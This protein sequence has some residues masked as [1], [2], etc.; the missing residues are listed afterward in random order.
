[1][2]GHT[3]LMTDFVVAIL[4]ESGYKYVYHSAGHSHPEHDRLVVYKGSRAYA[5]YINDDTVGDSYGD[6]DIKYDLQSPSC[7][8]ESITKE[9]LARMGPKWYTPNAIDAPGCYHKKFP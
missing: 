4:E 6:H 7:D 1:M 5:V 8:P 9:M 2:G 3:F